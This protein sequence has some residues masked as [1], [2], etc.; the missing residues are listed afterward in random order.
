MA[1]AFER[2][3]KVI[4]FDFDGVVLDSAQAKT[5]AFAQ[6]YHG[7]DKEKI[8]E[9]IRYQERHG[10]IGRQQKFEYFEEHVFGRTVDPKKIMQLCDQ[11]ASIVDKAMVEAPFVP[12]AAQ[13]LERLLGRIPLHVVSGMPDADLKAVLR[14][15]G[16][17]HYFASAA[18]SPK[19][20]LAEFRRILRS[21]ECDPKDALAVGDS[22]TEFDA[23]LELGIPFLAVVAQGAPDFFPSDVT[24]CQDLTEFDTLVAL[25]I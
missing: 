21:E 1:K 8:A 24:R 4:I 20:K 13:L 2:S 15:R 11:F 10:G 6:C 7:E 18:G 12:G 3:P 19:T 17:E 14:R 22:R 23:S 9:V 5:M 16:L 25:R